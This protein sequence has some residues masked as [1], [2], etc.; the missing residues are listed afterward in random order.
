MK[1]KCFHFI[2]TVF[3][4]SSEFHNSAKLIGERRSI[5]AKCGSLSVSKNEFAILGSDESNKCISITPRIITD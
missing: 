3:F 2:E 5:L 1:Q 4:C